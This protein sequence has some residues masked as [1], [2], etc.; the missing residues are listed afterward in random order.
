M[1]LFQ[2]ICHIWVKIHFMALVDNM[3]NNSKASFGQDSTKLLLL[4]QFH[5]SMTT[6]CKW[7][8]GK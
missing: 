8:I 7:W 2:N 1:K 3:G 4:G 5:L 6:L